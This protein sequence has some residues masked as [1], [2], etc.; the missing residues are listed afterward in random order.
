MTPE[1]LHSLAVNT[2]NACLFCFSSSR[3]RGHTYPWHVTYTVYSKW[4]N[5]LRR[6]HI[7][8]SSLFERIAVPQ[9]SIRLCTKF[10]LL[11]VSVAVTL[12]LLPH[13]LHLS[14]SILEHFLNN[15]LLHYSH[16][17]LW[18][19]RSRMKN[20]K[21]TTKQRHP[22]SMLLGLYSGLSLEHKGLWE[23]LNICTLSSTGISKF[24][25]PP[26]VRPRVQWLVHHGRRDIQWLIP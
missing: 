22:M 6:E 1:S 17:M 15:V 8:F 24:S 13:T 20:N 7:V 5:C 11:A 26:P 18:Y 3:S 10:I 2:V 23:A 14:I 25:F 21:Q 19:K 16:P 9:R 4:Y 12:L